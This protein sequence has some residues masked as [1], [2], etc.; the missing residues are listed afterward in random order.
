MLLGSKARSL[1]RPLLSGEESLPVMNNDKKAPSSIDFFTETVKLYRIVGRILLNIYRINDERDDRPGAAEEV[2][3]DEMMSELNDELVK[4][5]S[6]LPDTLRWQQPKG[7][8][9]V[10]GILERQSH[11]LHVRFLHA[12]I[13]LF[14]PSFLNLCRSH[15]S[16]D[17]SNGT[18]KGTGSLPEPLHTALELIDAVKEYSATEATGAWWYN[19]FYTRTAATVVLLSGACPPVFENLGEEAW[20]QAWTNCIEILT[21]NLPQY[22]PVKACLKTLT[23]LRDNILRQRSEAEAKERHASPPDLATEFDFKLDGEHFDPFE[24]VELDFFTDFGFDFTQSL[25]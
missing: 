12:R 16:K 7:D 8:H 3:N 17:D 18:T 1:P 6:S 5:A 22:A 10:T 23:A 25:S 19:V 9:T 2:R 4:F 11:V 13:L 24:F 21:Q 15:K 20:Q 14:Q